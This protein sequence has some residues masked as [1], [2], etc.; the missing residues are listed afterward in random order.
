MIRDEKSATAGMIFLM[1]GG[2]FV[3]QSITTLRVGEAL[4]MGPG[5]FPMLSGGALAD[6]ASRSSIIIATVYR[7]NLRKAPP[8][9][10]RWTRCFPGATS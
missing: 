7:R 10:R 2:W 6:S 1:L 5:Y 8:T 3:Y 9:A 4:R